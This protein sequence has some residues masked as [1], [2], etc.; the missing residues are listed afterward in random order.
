MKT[1]PATWGSLETDVSLVK[2]VDEGVPGLHPDFSL[3]K[4]EAEGPI[5]MFQALDSRKLWD[6][7]SVFL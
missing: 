4:P 2:S 1:G 7:K 6:N 5:K 3:L